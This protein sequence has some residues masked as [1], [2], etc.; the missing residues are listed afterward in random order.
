MT[1]QS[2]LVALRYGGSGRQHLK[3]MVPPT[4]IPSDQNNNFVYGAPMR[5][6]TPMKAVLGNFYGE[7]AGFEHRMRSTSI[8]F[9]DEHFRRQMLNP[10]KSHTRASALANSYVNNN[11]V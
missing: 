1:G 5:P 6:S 2:T 4:V 8:R 10:P 3:K 7:I 11:T 9:S